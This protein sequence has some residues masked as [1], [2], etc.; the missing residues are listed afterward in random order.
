M[1][2]MEPPLTFELAGMILGLAIYNA[3]NLDINFPIVLYKKLLDE[4]LT[5]QVCP[6]Y[7]MTS[8]F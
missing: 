5:L 2:S 7:Y 6:F 3:I 8:G 4:K 1:H